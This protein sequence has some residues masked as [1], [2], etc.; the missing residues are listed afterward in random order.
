MDLATV[1]GAPR[2]VDLSCGESVDVAPLMLR[3]WG[4]L[5]A[6]LKSNVASP[7]AV[8]KAN[9]EG[10]GLGRD[11]RQAILTAAGLKPWPPRPG[12]AAWMEAFDRAE[13]Q[14]AATR[15]FLVSVFQGD[16]AADKYAGRLNAEDIAALYAAAFGVDADPKA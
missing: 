11:D 3:Q 8:A 15:A 16:E 14:Q 12:S 6:W 13:D 1:S 10:S 7:L 2:R 5:Q 4:Y 9:L